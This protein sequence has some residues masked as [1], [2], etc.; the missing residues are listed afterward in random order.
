MSHELE[1]LV[2]FY[3]DRSFIPFPISTQNIENGQSHFNINTRKHCSF[4]A[5]YNRRDFYKITLIKGVGEVFYAGN[6]LLI[7]RPALLLPCPDVPYTWT[8]ISD[9]QD[10]YYCLFN[11]AF[12]NDHHSFDVFK[13]SALF[14][15]LTHPVVFLDSA[16][17]HLIESY[18]E[19]M[20]QMAHSEYLYKY[21]VIRNLLCLIMHQLIC[22]SPIQMDLQ[23]QSAP[24]RLLHLFEDL[25]D[26]QFPLDSPAYPLRMKTPADFAAA[27]NVHVN[28]LNF[29]IKTATGKTTFTILKNRIIEEAKTLLINTPW[30]VSQ[31]GYTL[32][33]EHPSHF[34]SFFKKSVGITP[35]QF[36]QKQLLAKK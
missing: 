2:D 4:A 19:Q 13:K 22:G 23:N 21:D 24:S 1:T 8:S 17:L 14:K 33:Y 7:D 3:R 29:T 34:N 10:G 28:H 31:V 25:L 5:P 11:A 12:F 16:T 15:P 32:G 36:K 20:L 35:L 27:L 30:D 9:E 18:F 6:T 26:Q